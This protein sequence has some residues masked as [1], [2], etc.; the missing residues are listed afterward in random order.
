M[1]YLPHYLNHYIAGEESVKNCFL[2]S[3]AVLVFWSVTGIILLE[4]VGPTL[5][6]DAY[7]WLVNLVFFIWGA[8]AIYTASLTSHAISQS[9]VRA[10]LKFGARFLNFLILLPGMGIIMLVASGQISW[11]TYLSRGIYAPLN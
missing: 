9:L 2:S 1:F 8:L 6:I 10:S 5:A 4:W 3:L 11:M 7:V